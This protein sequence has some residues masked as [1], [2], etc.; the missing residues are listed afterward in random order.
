M[1]Q[2]K[3]LI[4]LENLQNPSY[5]TFSI[6]PVYKIIYFNDTVSTGARGEPRVKS[7]TTKILWCAT[8]HRLYYSSLPSQQLQFA[9]F[10]LRIN[11]FVFHSFFTVV[12]SILVKVIVQHIQLLFVRECTNNSAVTAK[13]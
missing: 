4:L 8:I 5:S 11:Y 7:A 1:I 10:V 13:Q 3:Q 6:H 9:G 12:A 2:L